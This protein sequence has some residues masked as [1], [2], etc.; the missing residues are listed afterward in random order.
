MV[1]TS[2]NPEVKEE[3][4]DSVTVDAAVAPSPL[5]GKR[6]PPEMN[7]VT[8]VR[9]PSVTPLLSVLF[10]EVEQLANA[11]REPSTLLTDTTDKLIQMR[12][13]LKTMMD[14]L[15]NCRHCI[16]RGQALSRFPRLVVT[17]P[18]QSGKSTLIDFILQR[19]H[20][21]TKLDSGANAVSKA[22]ECDKSEHSLR[23]ILSPRPMNSSST[24]LESHSVNR[25]SDCS[26][27]FSKLGGLLFQK[28]NGMN[29]MDE[30]EELEGILCSSTSNASIFVPSERGNKPDTNHN[31]EDAAQ[32]EA[33][34]LPFLNERSRW[35]YGRG[36]DGARIRQPLRLVKLASISGRRM[37][38]SAGSDVFPGMDKNSPHG[39][40]MVVISGRFDITIVDRIRRKKGDAAHLLRE[41]E[42]KFCDQANGIHSL[43][44]KSG[45]SGSR[46]TNAPSASAGSVGAG[47]GPFNPCR[48]PFWLLQENVGGGVRWEGEGTT[49]VQLSDSLCAE[50]FFFTLPCEVVGTHRMVAIMNEFF[51]PFA[52][53]TEGDRCKDG[54]GEHVTSPSNQQHRNCSQEKKGCAHDEEGDDYQSIFQLISD[55]TF[56]VLT[57]SDAIVLR[58]EGV[59][60]TDKQ[61]VNRSPPMANSL[62]ELVAMF[63]REMLRLFGIHVDSWQV[64]PFSG[65]MSRVTRDVLTEIYEAR[66]ARMDLLDADDGPPPT[67]SALEPL[68]S[69]NVSALL[70]ITSGV[71]NTEGKLQLAITEF[72]DVMYGQRFKKSRGRFSPGQMEE[73]VLQHALRDAWKDSGACQLLHTVRCFDWN[74]LHYTV[75]QIALSLVIWCRQMHLV[76]LQAQKFLWQRLKSLQSDLQ[77][78]NRD[79]DRAKSAVRQLKEESIPRQMTQSIVFRVQKRF[80]ELTI[81]FWWTLLTLLD[82]ENVR[83]GV[84]RSGSAQ[85]L[86]STRSCPL[87]LPFSSLSMK[88]R[89]RLCRQ[90]HRFLDVYVTQR[91]QTQMSQLQSIIE[92]KNQNPGENTLGH[93]KQR[94]MDQEEIRYSLDADAS[95]LPPNLG[96]LMEDMRHHIPFVAQNARELK[97]TMRKELSLLLARLNTEVINY[98][99]AELANAFPALVKMCEVQRKIAKGKLLQLVTTVNSRETYDS[100]ERRL[101]RSMLSEIPRLRLLEMRPDQELEAFVT[102]LRSSLC[103]DQLVLYVK[104]LDDGWNGQ[105]AGCA[106]KTLAYLLKADWESD[107]RQ[108]RSVDY[109]QP[110]NATLLQQLRE[111]QDVFW[112][113]MEM[114]EMTPLPSDRGGNLA[115][116]EF[117]D[118]PSIDGTTGKPKEASGTH[119]DNGSSVSKELPQEGEKGSLMG[120]NDILV[121]KRNP[122][123]FF[124]AVWQEVFSAM[125]FR[126]WILLHNVRYASLL[127]NITLIFL[128]GQARLESVL[129]ERSCETEAVLRSVRHEMHLLGV[130][131]PSSL[132]RLSSRAIGAAH[133]MKK[134]NAETIISFS[135]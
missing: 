36:N 33:S 134:L 4:E 42:K 77:R 87:L 103:Q 55:I 17:G 104:H 126:P 50:A 39:G 83:Y 79:D 128:R 38:K 47:V 89:K 86:T 100:A 115:C 9:A 75:S 124:L 109:I 132:K 16:R 73:L 24:S 1:S 13:L 102:G 116:I 12:A 99:M 3:T 25:I 114:T 118:Q 72:C 133:N 122:I 49:A 110:Q 37:S 98:F 61:L 21:Q 129:K 43:T 130:E 56:Y 7:N 84:Y 135:S 127:N 35:R 94:S 41:G 58:S 97:L 74:S 76:L 26:T 78:I 90:Y 120:S 92:E 71:V 68:F 8:A 48:A 62:P 45:V 65:P 64:I 23:K 81:R 107:A 54:G 10:M 91:Y 105:Y 66:L 121:S 30:H 20:A 2:V 67:F 22:E 123:G 5:K 27:S 82:E 85:M 14:S 80:E 57:F 119:V 11:V 18:S 112:A 125:S 106:A 19:R 34:N 95:T 117:G 108:L 60:T 113:P 28:P 52:T 51:E 46:Q 101:L 32:H 31:V 40:S 15:R 69:L 29:G 44:T 6:M 53:L 88:A 131:L 96:S 93:A 63:Q 70:P 111:Y 59:Q